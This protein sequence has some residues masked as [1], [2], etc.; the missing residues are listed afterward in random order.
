MLLR[1]P[2]LRTGV[3]ILNSFN[4]L[5]PEKEKMPK[6]IQIFAKHEIFRAEIRAPPPEFFVA[7]LA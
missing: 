1:I 6:N 3:E 4:N 2:S 5:Y 7:R